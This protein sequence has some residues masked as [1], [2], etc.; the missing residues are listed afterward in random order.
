VKTVF[1]DVDTQL[2]FVFPAGALYVPG[3]ERLVTNL[4]RLT[5]FAKAKGIPI[6][7]TADA[8]TEDDLEFK[9]WNP[10][11][12]AGTT[13]QQKAAGTLIPNAIVLPSREGAFYELR[14][15]LQA[16]PQVIVEKQQIDCFTNPNLSPLLETFA[17][18]R[19]ILYGVVT[20]VCVQCAAV[21]LLDRGVRVELVTDSV[22]SLNASA[23]QEM[24]AAFQARGGEVITV[25]RV[26]G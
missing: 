7:S 18:D 17:A 25:D 4:G 23:E 6:I 16:A 14:E 10:H 20:E 2:D 24:I 22:K 12:V 8:H 19:Y 15:K 1:F 21:W 11:C 5:A 13:G 9:T 3:A 26:T